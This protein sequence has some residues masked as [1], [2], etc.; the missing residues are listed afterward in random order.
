MF[1]SADATKPILSTIKLNDGRSQHGNIIIAANSDL[2]RTLNGD[3]KFIEFEFS[4][5]QRSYICKTSIAEALPTAIPKKKKL[6][7]G[8]Q[9]DEDFNPHRVLK[10]KPEAS[11]DDIQ[12]AYHERAK[13]YHPDR[14]AGTELPDEMAKYA[15]NMTQLI[16]AAY[17]ILHAQATGQAGEQPEAQADDSAHQP[18]PQQTIN[19]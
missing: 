4:N 14:F 15:K 8:S 7:A 2:P 12:N 9:N 18:A 1:S 10:I 16:N 5:G 3:G 17:Q 11:I 6:E 13:M 19:L